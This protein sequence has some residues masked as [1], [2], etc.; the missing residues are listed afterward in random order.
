MCPERKSDVE[1]CDKDLRILILTPVGRD[2]ALAKQELDRN[3]LATRVCAGLDELRTQIAIGAG[4]VLIAEEALPGHSA[5]NCH[6]WLESEQAWS[7]LPI[8]VLLGRERTLHNLPL[9]RALERRPNVNFLERPV[10]RR[11]LIS[12]LRAAVESR[13]LQYS[14]RDALEEL[15]TLNRKKDE[16]LATLSHELRNP[17][18][19][20][21]SAI[22]VLQ[23]L[24]DDPKSREKA[25]RL[26]S[27]LERQTDHLVRLVDDLL[28]VAR[29]TSGK[30]ELKKSNVLLQDVIHQAVEMSAPHV[31]EAAHKLEVG[32]PVEPLVVTGDRVRLTQVLANLLNNSARYTPSG[33]RIAISL[34]RDADEAAISVKDNGIGVSK[35]MLPRIFELFSQSPNDENHKHGGLGIGLALARSLVEMHGGSISARSDGSGQGS[36]F[37]VRLPLDQQTPAAAA[38]T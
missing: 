5:G 11:S 6:A 33:G 16:F 35:E 29:I 18:A 31:K 38:A 2:A 26:L 24:G 3:G 19:P 15:Q 30:I 20:I 12:A 21:R 22:Y 23:N 28:E 25:H 17:L 8:I 14:V 9:L 27:M 7:S 13:R 1:F 36:E 34:A 4:A 37:I 32:L 10:P